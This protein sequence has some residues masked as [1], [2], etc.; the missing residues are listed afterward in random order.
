MKTEL[1]AMNSSVA[2][3]RFGSVVSAKNNS[4]MLDA[5]DN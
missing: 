4:I 2:L 3:D 1:F 5:F